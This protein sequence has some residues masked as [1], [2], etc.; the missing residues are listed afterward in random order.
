MMFIQYC[1]ILCSNQVIAALPISLHLRLNISLPSL[2]WVEVRDIMHLTTKQAWQYYYCYNVGATK[3]RMHFDDV[4][5][6]PLRYLLSPLT[7]LIYNM[8]ICAV[9]NQMR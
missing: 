8:G 2:L 1:Y 3:F 7:V 5:A 6:R 4:Y 9:F